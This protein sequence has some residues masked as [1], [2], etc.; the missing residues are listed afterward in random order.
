MP[1]A[2]Y[3]PTICFSQFDAKFKQHTNTHTHTYWPCILG[4]MPHLAFSTNRR[5]PHKESNDAP[6]DDGDD[7]DDGGDDEL[8]EKAASDDDVSTQARNY[9]LI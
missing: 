9:Q 2:K 5:R 4:G 7:D 6:D 8:G 1:L 3:K